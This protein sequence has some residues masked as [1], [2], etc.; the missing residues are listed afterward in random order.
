[1]P[2]PCDTENTI[3]YELWTGKL[4]TGARWAPDEERFPR[5]WLHLQGGQ[6]ANWKK[7]LGL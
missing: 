4:G 6:L 2:C 3:R 7:E 5:L 1:M